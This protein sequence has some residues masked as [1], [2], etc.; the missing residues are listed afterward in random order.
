MAQ[1]ESRVVS[2]VTMA[3]L[4]HVRARR[5]ATDTVMWTRKRL[6]S[7]S[8]RTSHRRH[9]PPLTTQ[10]RGQLQRPSATHIR[11][12]SSFTAVPS[13]DAHC[14]CPLSFGSAPALSLCPTTNLSQ[15][16]QS[17]T[18]SSTGSE[19]S[20]HHSSA[21]SRVPT[22]TT[23]SDTPPSRPSLSRR[24]NCL[25]NNPPLPRPAYPAGQCQGLTDTLPSDHVLLPVLVSLCRAGR[26]TRGPDERGYRPDVESRVERA[27][28]EVGFATSARRKSYIHQI[29]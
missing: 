11:S 7:A 27:V 2:K 25:P 4:R 26:A 23:E 16:P 21:C 24:P 9:K 1:H 3:N 15:L 18:R 20:L 17:Y 8:T 5:G 14:A 22:S 19:P 6:R 12:A 28:S 29:R 13:F 10:C